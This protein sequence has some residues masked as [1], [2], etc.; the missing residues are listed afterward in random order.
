V[1]SPGCNWP[2]RSSAWWA[3]IDA[4][5]ELGALEDL[6]SQDVQRIVAGIGDDAR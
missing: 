4:D 2:N 5:T 1:R 6:A 3:D